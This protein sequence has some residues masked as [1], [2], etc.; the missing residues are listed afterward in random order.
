MRCSP[1]PLRKPYACMAENK[2]RL[3]TA[4]PTPRGSSKQFS[5][6]TTN[7]I[8]KVRLPNADHRWRAGLPVTSKIALTPVTGTRVPVS[9]YADVTNN[10]IF[11]VNAGKITRRDV[12]TL[13]SDGSAAIVQGIDRGARVVRDGQSGVADGDVVKN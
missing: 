5:P 8:V 3:P 13:A 7:F 4:P 2:H 6:G 1:R 9:A 11:V 10:A 12:Q